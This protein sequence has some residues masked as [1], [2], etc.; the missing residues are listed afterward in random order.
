MEQGQE[1]KKYKILMF[2]EDEPDL[3]ELYGVAFETAGFSIQSV[4]N[5][6]EALLIIQKLIKEEIDSPSAIILDV[7][8]PGISGMDILREIR[9][10]EKFNRIPVIIFTNYSSDKIKN[11]ANNTK[12]T[13]YI[14]KVDASPAQLVEIT[15]RKIKESEA[16]YNGKKSA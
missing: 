11:E 1:R 16:L 5:G 8:L 15:I 9:K 2:V 10:H 12:N 7:L 13:E 6:E 4:N 14:L 3:V